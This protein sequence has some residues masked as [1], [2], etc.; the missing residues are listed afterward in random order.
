MKFKKSLAGVLSAVVAAAALPIISAGTAAAAE[1]SSVVEIPVAQDKVVIYNGITSAVPDY[2][3]R[4]LCIEIYN[5]MDD[6]YTHTYSDPPIDIEYINSLNGFLGIS[7]TF[8][9]TGLD[10]KLGSVSDFST[11]MTFAD[12]NWRS[13]KFQISDTSITGDGTYTVTADFESKANGIGRFWV[14]ID[15]LGNLLGLEDLEVYNND[16]PVVISDFVLKISLDGNWETE[17]EVTTTPETEPETTTT[18]E[19]ETETT[20]TPETTEP[21]TTTPKTEPTVTTT[22]HA[23]APAVTTSTT[24]APQTTAPAAT[25]ETAAQPETVE[26]VQLI[27]VNT[28]VQLSADKGVLGDGVKLNVVIDNAD[29]STDA[30]VYILDITLV[31]AQGAA[32]QPNG[33]VTVKIPIPEDLVG[34]DVYYVYYQADDG[35]LT[36]MHAT[37]ES[38]Y[39]SF[40]TNHFSKYLL[41]SK[42]LLDNS[43]A[44]TTTSAPAASNSGSNS[45]K[46]VN[47]GA[48]LLI[49]PAIAAAAGVVISKKRK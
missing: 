23:A 3:M 30:H 14:G 8:S 13:P 20:T 26:P 47:T 15:S 48:T 6:L 27:D 37:L 24:A 9:V 43:A 10:D 32:V 4:G 25:S 17:P 22:P 35:T 33:Y 5:A 31:N 46:N 2:Y 11:Y 12:A 18:P 42:K 44:T 45:D 21:E 40:T 49:I 7:L 1:Q 16:G 38:G 29:I 19:T 39:V 41:T 28:G 36:D 34:S